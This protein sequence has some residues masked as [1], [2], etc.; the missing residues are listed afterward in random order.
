MA[1]P[2]VVTLLI[3]SFSHEFPQLKRIRK[4]LLDGVGYETT[5]KKKINYEYNGFSLFTKLETKVAFKMSFEVHI[6]HAF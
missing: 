3:F 1:V 6:F 5:N 2:L 4:D